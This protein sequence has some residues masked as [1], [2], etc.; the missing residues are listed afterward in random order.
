MKRL[1]NLLTVLAAFLNLTKGCGLR[2][3]GNAGQRLLTIGAALAAR[4]LSS[5]TTGG[6][7]QGVL[8]GT[9]AGGLLGTIRSHGGAGLGS[10]LV[11]GTSGLALSGVTSGLGT[12]LTAVGGGLPGGSGGVLLAGLG[13]LAAQRLS[14]GVSSGGI[15]SGSGL[16][17][18][19][20]SSGVLLGQVIQQ[21]S[22]MAAG[23]F[24]T[25][26]GATSSS[27]RVTTNLAQHTAGIIVQRPSGGS[28][29]GISP[30]GAS[31]PGS[32]PVGSGLQGDQGA[33]VGVFETGAG[34]GSPSG[35]GAL[36]TTGLSGGGASP[37]SVPGPRNFSPGGSQLQSLGQGTH[38]I[39]EAMSTAS[40]VTSNIVT[41]SAA[42]IGT[43]L[44][45]STP[46]NAPGPSFP[47]SVNPGQAVQQG[48]QQAGHTVA[49]GLSAVG[50]AVVS[51]NSFGANI[52]TSAGGGIPRLTPA[53]SSGLSSGGAL[54][55]VG[56]SLSSGVPSG[57]GLRQQGAVQGVDIV[58]GLLGGAAGRPAGG[59]PS[60]GPGTG[61]ESGLVHSASEEI[62]ARQRLRDGTQ[63]GTIG[64]GTP[65]LQS[66]ASMI[67]HTAGSTATTLVN[68]ASSLSG[69][70]VAPGVG[71]GRNPRVPTSGPES[72]ALQGV[73][74]STRQREQTLG[75]GIIG[76]VRPSLP[77]TAGITNQITSSSAS[78]SILNVASNLAGNPGAATPGVGITQS[79]GGAVTGMVAGINLGQRLGQG[80]PQG[81]QPLEGTFIGS[82]GATQLSTT[83]TGTQFSGSFQGGNPGQG[84]APGTQPMSQGPGAGSHVTVSASSH[85]TSTWQARTH[86]VRG[87][88][89]SPAGG[90]PI[91]PG[92]GPVV[93]APSGGS[94]FSSTG[95]SSGTNL[96]G[97]IVEAS[98][99]GH[100]VGNPV[101]T[102]P[103]AGLAGPVPN[104]AGVS[105]SNGAISGTVRGI[106]HH[107]QIQHRRRMGAA[108]ATGIALGTVATALAVGA[109]GTGIASAIQSS[110]AAG[111]RRPGGCSRSGCSGGCGRKR[112]SVPPYKVPAEVLNNILMDF[113]RRY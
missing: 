12:R 58:Q 101:T 50:S 80:T 46:T 67:T 56:G 85:S 23:G 61:M 26:S 105:R 48:L 83:S 53:S 20:G 86:V 71:I 84:P 66:T 87:S 49:G 29:Q 37:V 77:S 94:V 22:Q 32:R 93:G 88:P 4:R 106:A 51:A 18:S 52:V 31:G 57:G 2:S 75:G 113:N 110:M 40:L 17:V 16:A 59:L 1:L 62:L 98:A 92:N 99:G 21:P 54:N 33:L 35:V 76:P 41:N 47:A 104:G 70:D 25:A 43:Q 111:G 107:G 36:G 14:S 19:G 30:T 78:T 72:L 60:G 95:S 7:L 45:G 8:G 63:A 103:S 38:G 109:I 91:I 112:R 90:L 11:S 42:G 89:A 44:P 28:P 6:S 102:I 10:G 65:A 3:S 24:I 68:T 13:K 64:S 82:G 27:T 34:A 5:S 69:V 108:A 74:Q 39:R 79:P 96:L 100:S 81:G 55:P 73:G 15:L 9:S 97:A